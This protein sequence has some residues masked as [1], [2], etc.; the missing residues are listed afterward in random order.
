MADYSGLSLVH[1]IYQRGGRWAEDAFKV[2]ET[3]RLLQEKGILDED[4]IQAYIEQHRRY[5]GGEDIAEGAI[6]FGIGFAYVNHQ[7]HKETEY[8]EQGLAW[9]QERGSGGE[10]VTKQYDFP[11]SLFKYAARMYAHKVLRKEEPPQSMYKV[12]WDVFGLGQAD[13][14]LG[15]YERGIGNLM[16]SLANGEL[17][18]AI[19][20]GALLAGEITQTAAAGVTRPLDPINQ[21]I[22]IA[23]GDNFVNVDRRQGNKVLNNSLRYVDRVIENLLPEDSKLK[24]ALT[25]EEKASATRD[26]STPAQPGKVV[27]YREVGRQSYTERMFNTIG[28]ENW[29]VGFFGGIP[30]ADAKLNSRLFYHLERRAELLLKTKEF[31][32]LSTSAKRRKVERILQLAKKDT[33]DNIKKS[34]VVKDREQELLF[35][36]D[37][38]YSERDIKRALKDLDISE[39]LEDLNYLQL[40][41]IEAYMD[42]GDEY[43]KRTTD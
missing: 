36:L 28:K 25:K 2:P 38:K 40:Q 23:E 18:E 12:F 26:F 33:K 24:R 11:E 3:R 4:K 29:R 19:D 14:S 16:F 20:Y 30:E 9:D 8:M 10:T 31:K 41:T 6:K 43:I 35:S 13:R 1:R 39:D 7:A 17:Q 5:K 21:A 34:V 37:K 22:A 15:A 42:G 32:D 27:G